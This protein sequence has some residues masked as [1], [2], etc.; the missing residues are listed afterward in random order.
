MR[1]TSRLQDKTYIDRTPTM[2]NT[3]FWV[4]LALF[5]TLFFLRINLPPNDIRGFTSYQVEQTFLARPTQTW[6]D[7]INAA[8]N[9]IV[10]FINQLM[11]NYQLS[12]YNAQWDYTDFILFKYAG[13]EKLDMRMIA[14]PFT[15]WHRLEEE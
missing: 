15:W 6:F 3:K 2:D 10:R 7:N 14:L 12:Q 13:S 11:M 5:S 4:V 9:A 8:I 1:T